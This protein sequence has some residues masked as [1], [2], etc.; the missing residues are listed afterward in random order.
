[1]DQYERTGL[2]LLCFGQEENDTLAVLLNE[3]EYD[4]KRI[5]EITTKQQLY[6]NKELIKKNLQNVIQILESFES[7]VDSFQ[8]RRKV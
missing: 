3:D 6:S 7:Y 1:M 2:D 8:V 4:E 5:N